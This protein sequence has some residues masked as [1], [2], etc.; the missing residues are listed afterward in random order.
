MS[1]TIDGQ[2]VAVEP[3]TTI[4]AAA[5]KLGIEIPTLCHVEGLEPS[6]SCF[7]CAVQVEGLPHLSPACAMPVTDGMVITTNS[8]DVRAARRMALE[9]LLSDH[10]G[11]C[12]A[13]CGV[14][15]PA[16]LDIPGF[17][18]AFAAGRNRRA[19]EII[20]ERLALP[21]ALG[22]ICPRLCEKE[23][24][25]SAHDEGLAIAALHRF[26]ADQELA[27]ADPFVPAGAEPSGKKVGIVGAGPAG[28]TAAYYLL[29]LGHACTLFDAHPLP[30]GMLRYGIPE[31]RLP[32]AAL[33]GEIEII[34]RLGAEFRMNSRWGT[35]FTLAELRRQFDALFLG[36]GAQRS[37]NLGCEGEELALSG[38]EFLARVAN[39][40]RPEIGDD[41]VVI[42]GG[43]TAMDASRTAVRLGAKQVRV[44]YR[45]TRTEM[46][47]LMEE[48][49][50]AEAEGVQIEYLVAP[51]QLERNNDQ[52]LRVTCQ[53]MQLGEPDTSG[54]RRPVPIPGSQFVAGASAVIA[55][56]GQAV[57]RSLG[58]REG[59]K[60]T[61][62]GIAADPKTL[63]TSLA[64]VFA[65]GDG[66]SG[67]D[68]AVRAAAAGRLAAI[69]ID[70]YLSGQPVIGSPEMINV[71]MRALDEQELAALFRRI[72]K[73]PRVRGRAKMI[74]APTD[75]EQPRS[76]FVE[77]EAGLSE[78]QAIEEARRCLTCGCRKAEDCRVRR[79]A[80]EYGV[81]PCRFSGE[82]RRFSRDLSHPEI[83]YEPGKCIMCEACVRI[84][85]E[86]KEELGVAIV[87]RGFSVTMQVPF[88]RPLSEGL[89]RVAE[90]CAQACPTGALAL[91][92]QR[93][94]DLTVCGH[95]RGD[96]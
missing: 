51:T 10:A 76:S 83:V 37:Q 13:P 84:A 23:C 49:E 87:G 15:C 60:V 68:L 40:A 63:A 61:A 95:P 62:W 86:A 12:V 31:Y 29:Q 50:A 96:A 3:G 47:C 42:G 90:R 64:G 81:D 88:E 52:T 44:L 16:G 7:M 19:A 54:R 39:G 73:A 53:H 70:Q 77:V 74:F 72:E 58:A 46:P 69:S 8:Q 59:L 91:R 5:A 57:D 89:Q 14:T 55:A 4:L 26:A 56:I 85:A 75:V 71:Q 92:T 18:H 28:L 24:R 21:G 94:C 2:P 20:A 80:T 66:V 35:D 36:I 25:R 9:L 82:R 38:T 34:K 27:S 22:R 1:L 32:K 43:N 93:A 30:G 41:V 78:A 67:A 17:V 65:G 33:D 6:A 48:V 79:Y 45:R 11:D